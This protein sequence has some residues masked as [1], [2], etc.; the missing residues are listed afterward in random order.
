L[1]T[2]NYKSFL[3][4][5]GFTAVLTVG[6]FILDVYT[7]AGVVEWVMYAIPLTLTLTSSRPRAPLY[8]ASLVTLLL[9]IGFVASPPGVTPLYAM[10]NR[11]LGMGLMWGF[12]LALVNRTQMTQALTDAQAQTVQAESA[13]AD[14]EAAV[15][16]AVAGQRRAEERMREENMR[17]E[18]IVQSAMDALISVDEDQKII[19][20][21]QAAER[22]FRWSAGELVGRSMDCLIPERFRRTHG[23]H[24]RRFGQSG[25]TTRKMGALG[26]ITGLRAGGEE[27]PIE[28]SISQVGVEGKRYFTVILRDITER[29]RLENELAEREGLLRTIIETEPECVKVLNLDGTVQTMNAAGLAM[30]EAESSQDILGKDVSRLVVSEFRVPFR[31]LIAKAAQGES[32]LL[33]FEIMGLKGGR[34]WLET[35]AVPLRGADGIIVAVLGVTRDTTA[36]KQAEASLRRVQGLFE[37]I[38][39][40]SKDAIGY[41]SLDGKFVLA[42]QA[43]AKLT[44]YSQDELLRMN[45]G[46]LTPDEYRGLQATAIGRVIETGEPA[47]FEREYIRKDGSRVPVALT[48]FMVKGEDGKPAGLAAIVRDITERKQAEAAM[49]QSE[50]RYRRLVQVSPDAIFVLRGDAIMFGNGEGL[51]LL[52]ATVESQIVGRMLVDFIPVDERAVVRRRLSRVAEEQEQVPLFE[53]A[54]VR[55]DGSMIEVEVTVAHYSDQEGPAILVVARDITERKRLQAQLRRTERVAEL[56]TVA[57]GM[58]HEIGTPMNVILGRAEYLMER[59]KEEPVRKGLQTIVTQ[60]ERIT[61]VMNQLLAFARRRPVEHRALD[62]RETIEDNLEIFYERLSHNNITVETSFAED[63]PLVHADA[64]QICQVLINLVMNA[65]H[66]MPNG[67]TMRLVLAPDRDMVKLTVAD[68]GSGMPQ[69]VIAKVFEPFFTTKEFGKGTGLGLTVVKGII[70]EHSGTIHVESEPGKGT[71]FTIGLPINRDAL[72]TSH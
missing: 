54:L 57:S 49:R 40:S 11:L 38:V 27:F 53:Q 52:G 17:L 45:Y 2:P 35:H 42:N 8:F 4:E 22:M 14:A 36:R 18:G 43:L 72:V 60:V 62:L 6:I 24:I 46:E 50:E 69:E 56:G 63:C 47:E 61:R 9:A 32:G 1:Q 33:E 21:N 26:M 41:A 67:G 30:I 70:E 68:T 25:V 31:E 16:G 13:R 5:Y 19:L 12:A 3:A 58:A 64:D 71:V 66:A 51:R 65:I 34:R 23:E 28:A 7:P 20:F 59:T 10:I 44:G 29:R 39:E 55:L 37:D 48:V 15:L